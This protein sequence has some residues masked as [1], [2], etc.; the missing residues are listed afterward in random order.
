AR[1]DRAA[2][3]PGDAGTDK[4]PVACSAWNDNRPAGMF[5]RARVV[6][7]RDRL[8]DEAVEGALVEVPFRVGALG[9]LLVDDL[10]ELGEADVAVVVPV[11]RVGVARA[12]RVLEAT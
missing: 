8:A 12:V 5:R 11:V 9:W 10:V 4:H 7:S 6:G 2:T 1:G 3:R